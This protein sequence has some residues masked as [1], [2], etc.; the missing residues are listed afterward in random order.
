VLEGSNLRLKVAL[1]GAEPFL[2]PVTAPG[3]VRCGPLEVEIA[4]IDRGA[5]WSLANVSG[6]PAQVEAVSLVWDLPKVGETV[7]VFLNGYQSWSR[8]GAAVLGET[9]DPSLHPNSIELARAMFHANPKVVP[10]AELR[11]EMTTVIDPGADGPLICYGFDGALSEHDGTFR[12]RRAGRGVEVQAEP[13]LGGAVI[14]AGE[15]RT[16][17]SVRL[18]RGDSAQR[19]LA[20]WAAGTGV[21]GK[22]RVEAPYQVG[23]CS[24]YQYFHGLDEKAV[25]Q[26]LALSE[27]WP[28]EVFQIDDGYQAV[29]G[30]WLDTNEKFSSDLSD[31]ASAISSA[32]KTPGIWLAPFLA[33]PGSATAAALPEMLA[34]ASD[35]KG[36]L[37]GAINEGWGGPVFVLD[38]T[39]TE[40][41][42]HLE[43]L[44]SALVRAGFRYL[45]LDFLFAPSLPGKYMDPS[46]TPA[47]RVRAGLEAIRKGAGPQTFLLGCGCPLGPAIGIV[48]GMRIGPD[49]AP[50]WDPEPFF[51]QGYEAESPATVNAWRNT[52]ARSFMHRRLWL[53]DPDCIMLRTTQTR[54]DRNAARAW[55]LVVGASGG[56]AMVSDD[57]SLLDKEAAAVLEESVELGRAVDQ[58]A[59]AGDSPRCEDLMDK[60]VPGILAVS[61]VRLQGD[62]LTRSVE[63]IREAG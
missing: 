41:L 59:F 26:N 55:A 29:V 47:Q 24:W 32:G 61:G 8:S 44:S 28:F 23:W 38:T 42:S 40:T 11:S 46:R 52:F 6:E 9:E 45:K 20:E 7:R 49:V 39:R 10:P 35:G 33:A 34:E 25:K 2:A 48:D 57:L 1:V 19:L 30:D 37:V 15:G 18:W 56:M 63:V 53:N 54:L 27:S 50:Y 36:P 3:N 13:Y 58:A 17:N 14:E 51:L 5:G 21:A 12:L 43:E 22:A 62:P 16:L 31:L 4:E 60:E